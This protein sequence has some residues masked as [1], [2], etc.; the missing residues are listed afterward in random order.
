[1]F[2]RFGEQARRVIMFA[3]QEASELGSRSIAPEHILLGLIRV[4]DGLATRFPGASIQTIREQIQARTPPGKKI[5]FGGNFQF[6]SEGKRALMQ[7]AE[8]ADRMEDKQIGTGHL[9]NGIMRDENSFAR[10][11]LRRNIQSD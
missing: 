2:E 5:T 9:L 3:A 7:A 10:E 11:I 8:E 4:D 1:M 6:S